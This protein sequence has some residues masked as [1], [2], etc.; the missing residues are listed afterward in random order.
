[1]SAPTVYEGHSRLTSLLPRRRATHPV[2]HYIA[3]R[4]YRT[5]KPPPTMHLPPLLTLAL[6]SLT[7]AIPT[8]P[9]DRRAGERIG[10]LFNTDDKHVTASLYANT[11]CFSVADSTRMRL[12][13]GYRCKFY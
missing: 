5:I 10:L 6:P 12:A 9:L 4:T 13:K 11:G 8:L 1:M 2:S 7:L 3:E